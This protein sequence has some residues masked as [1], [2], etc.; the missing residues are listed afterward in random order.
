MGP[1][2]S[3]KHASN[4]PRWDIS[5]VP[6]ELGR[7]SLEHLTSPRSLLVK[8]QAKKKLTCRLIHDFVAKETIFC[9]GKQQEKVTL[10]QQYQK[11]LF[12]QEFE[13]E[14]KYVNKDIIAVH[15]NNGETLRKLHTEFAAFFDSVQHI[16]NNLLNEPNA[17][18]R[19]KM[20]IQS[21]SNRMSPPGTVLICALLVPN[22]V[23]LKIVS[24]L[25]PN[26]SNFKKQKR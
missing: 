25:T 19:R 6:K 22:K 2:T 16:L 15:T 13:E 3:T 8:E 11:E 5:G 24:P 4:G 23:R 14:I 20:M 7:V 17:I 9:D 10:A 18:Q 1:R 21:Y 12:V 26:G